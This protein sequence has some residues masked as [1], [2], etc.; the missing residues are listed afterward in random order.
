[1]TTITATGLGAAAR[2]AGERRGAA[3]DSTEERAA[4]LAGRSAGERLAALF[5]DH[6][7]R[8]FRLACRLTADREEARDLVQETFLRTARQ[9]EALPD[10]AAPG[11]GWL[12]RTLV[13]LCRDH[14]RRAVVR[15]RARL[16]LT[17][18]AATAAE[19]VPAVPG[20]ESRL[21][22]RTAVR[23]ALA[24]LPRRRRAVVVLHEIE[25]LPVREIAALL[26][27]AGVTVRW[28]LLAARR[29]LAAALLVTGGAAGGERPAAREAAK[30]AAKE[31]VREEVRR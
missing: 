30:E 29:Q 16:A 25:E 18:A 10:R 1:M 22:A 7:Q 27:I 8:L 11:E 15:S 6:H 23:A 4:D 9:M 20:A 17:A 14:H 12:V 3:M 2:A 26:G 13:N 19:L 24:G 21:M 5:D 31:A 28:H